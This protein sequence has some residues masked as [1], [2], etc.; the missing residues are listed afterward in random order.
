L[1]VSPGSRPPPEGAGTNPKWQSATHVVLELI[2]PPAG[3]HTPEPA[4]CTDRELY[5]TD[6]AVDRYLER[7]DRI[8]AYPR[9]R[10]SIE[11]IG[12][13]EVELA[14]PDITDP[15]RI[16]PVSG[17]GYVFDPEEIDV[18]TCII[19]RPGELPADW[20]VEA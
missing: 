6:H 16:H 1:V 13:V 8:E 4:E 20:R 18:T 9:S 19:P 7:V 10:I 12:A 17:V 5:V 3:N 14:A 15:V 2:V 11:F